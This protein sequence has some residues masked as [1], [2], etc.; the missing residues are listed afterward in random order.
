[1]YGVETEKYI[2]ML[3]TVI[4]LNAKTE[5]VVGRRITLSSSINTAMGKRGSFCPWSSMSSDKSIK[6]LGL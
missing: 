6:S 5:D 2:V 3:V 1:M 4:Y